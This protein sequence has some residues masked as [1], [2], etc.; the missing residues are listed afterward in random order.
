MMPRVIVLSDVHGNLPALRAVVA[1]LPDHDAAVVAGDHCLDGP[2]PA[3]VMDL[4]AELGWPLLLG[5]TD[6]DIVTPPA[7]LKPLKRR[8]VEWTR[9]QLGAGR[10]QRLAQLDFSARIRPDNPVPV[11][12]AAGEPEAPDR[13]GDRRSLLAVHANP[14]NLEDHLRPTM[15]EEELQPYLAGVDAGILAF[16]HLHIPYVRRVG[17]LLLVDVASVGHPRDGD[18]RACF[19]LLTW[20][21]HAWSARQERVPYDVEETVHRLRRCGMPDA[22]KQVNALLKASY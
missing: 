18:L 19:S 6:R 11:T 2:D 17:D 15:S 3:E 22:E 7:D 1:A 14:R 5:N 16:G 21:G 12:R 9:R 10:L 13:P 8:V 4:L 20:D